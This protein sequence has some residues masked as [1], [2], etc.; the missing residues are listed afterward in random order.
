MR[1][2]RF[3][4]P[5][6]P[7]AIA[8]VKAEF[9]SDAVILNTGKT[10]RPGLL[11][12]FTPRWVVVMAGSEFDEQVAVS[13]QVEVVEEQPLPEADP[14]PAATTE[15]PIGECL[16]TSTVKLTELTVSYLME[17]LRQHDVA[18]HHLDELR[19]MVRTRVEQ[20]GE[21]PRLHLMRLLAE[22]MPVSQPWS[23]SENG[24]LIVPMVGPTGVGKTTT[25]AKLAT[26]YA[27]LWGWRVG[28]ITAD[29]YRVAAVEQLRTYAD[30]LDV[31]LEVLYSAEDTPTALDRLADR[32]LILMDTA[33]RS[34]YV[35]EHMQELQGFINA[36][37]NCK[38][39][40]VV[41]ANVRYA[42]LS[43]MI[44]HFAKW[45]ALEGIIV[46]KIDETQAYGCLYNAVRRLNKPIAFITNGQSVP[47]DLEVADP[48]RLAGMLVGV[49]S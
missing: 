14:T 33:G 15:A 42:D 9:G 34:P 48:I 11:G 6:M 31:P 12:Y 35:E 30:I 29:T 27:L 1:V 25:I 26:N 19:D 43:A 3:V 8:M 18:P 16:T 17:R 37:G 32:Q 40:L 13:T 24:P 38:P 20:G 5:T 44:D 39:H 49:E 10:R 36:V 28:F 45:V 47:E 23:I 46:T 21:A 41:N 4:A 2:K 7:A 22:Q